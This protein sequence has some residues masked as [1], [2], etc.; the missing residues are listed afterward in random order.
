MDTIS[1]ALLCVLQVDTLSLYNVTG[2]FTP[3]VYYEQA[4]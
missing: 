2:E 1:D 3:L 4:E